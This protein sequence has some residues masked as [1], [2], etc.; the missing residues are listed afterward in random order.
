MCL[1]V[2]TVSTKAFVVHVRVCWQELL[3]CTWTYL[4]TRACAAPCACAFYSIR[5]AWE[6]PNQKQT[7]QLRSVVASWRTDSFPSPHTHRDRKIDQQQTE[8]IETEVKDVDRIRITKVYVHIL[9]RVGLLG[10]YKGA[11][12]RHKHMLSPRPPS[13]YLPTNRWRSAGTGLSWCL[14]SITGF[15]ATKRVTACY[16]PGQAENRTAS[17]V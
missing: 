15:S 2:S 9:S 17:W 11:P 14:L 12:V 6:S 4:S 8:K 1:D 7:T 16:Q 3:C 10:A 5:A 13:F